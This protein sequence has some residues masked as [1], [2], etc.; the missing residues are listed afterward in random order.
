MRYEI[1]TVNPVTGALGRLVASYNNRGHAIA[2]LRGLRRAARCSEVEYALESPG[3][4]SGAPWPAR[5]KR[6][7]NSK[8]S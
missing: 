1:W 6:A 8:A 7:V 2:R 5:G 4:G 3:I